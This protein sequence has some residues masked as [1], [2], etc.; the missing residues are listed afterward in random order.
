MKTLVVEERKKRKTM[1][2]GKPDLSNTLMDRIEILEQQ[3]AEDV[4]AVEFMKKL[5]K[6]MDNFQTHVRR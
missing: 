4:K 6:R 5:T 1:L 3:H 2:K